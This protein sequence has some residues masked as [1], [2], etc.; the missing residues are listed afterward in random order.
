MSID[1][2]KTAQRERVLALLR[3]GP[4]STSDLRAEQVMHPGGRVME[5][6]R[7]GYKIVTTWRH[8]PDHEG[9]IHRQGVYV[10]IAEAQR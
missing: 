8:V 3:N 4:A 10:L 2:T 1:L 7:E 9:V 6:R 5:L